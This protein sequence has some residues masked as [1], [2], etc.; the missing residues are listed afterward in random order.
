MIIRKKPCPFCGGKVRYI[1]YDP[2]R[3]NALIKCK[4]CRATAL[5]TAISE[6]EYLEKYTM[7]VGEA[8]DM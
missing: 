6:R 4:K 3:F 5:E 2:L 7:E 1:D 8:D